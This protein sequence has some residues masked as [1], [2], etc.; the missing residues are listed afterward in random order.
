[1]TVGDINASCLEIREGLSDGDTIV[2][3]GVSK[4]QDGLRVRVTETPGS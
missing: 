2:T 4:I 3:A 1:V